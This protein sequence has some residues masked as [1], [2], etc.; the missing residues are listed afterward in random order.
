MYRFIFVL[1]IFCVFCFAFHFCF[2]LV[3]EIRKKIGVCLSAAI[4]G[5]FY[6]SL[7]IRKILTNYKNV[8]DAT[9]LYVCLPFSIDFL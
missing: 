1:G 9:I 7:S 8:A 6:V 5:F 4:E 2:G 3:Y